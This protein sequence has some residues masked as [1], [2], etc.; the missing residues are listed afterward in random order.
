MRK[1][2]AKRKPPNG[3]PIAPTVVP[4]IDIDAVNFYRL[5][6]GLSFKE[7]SHQIQVKPTTLYAILRGRTQTKLRDT[8][9]YRIQQF[10]ATQGA[11]VGRHP[12]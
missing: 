4:A 8:T 5:E 11:H 7:L 1:K 10:C 3:A 2:P 12:R 9:A 6:H